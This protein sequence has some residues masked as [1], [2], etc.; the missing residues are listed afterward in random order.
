MIVWD[1]KRRHIKINKLHFFRQTSFYIIQ[2]SAHSTSNYKLWRQATPLYKN[3]TWQCEVILLC[4]VQSCWW[5]TSNLEAGPC[6]FLFIVH[7][8]KLTACLHKHQRKRGKWCPV[9][10]HL[11]GHGKYVT[12]VLNVVFNTVSINCFFISSEAVEK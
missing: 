8:N 12:T 9:Y 3:N 11:W 5:V 6:D 2:I 10:L 7:T 1:C 4:C